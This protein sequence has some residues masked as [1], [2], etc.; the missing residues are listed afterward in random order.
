MDAWSELNEPAGASYC[1]P[2]ALIGSQPNSPT[3]RAA[4]SVSCLAARGRHFYNPIFGVPQR[5]SRSGALAHIHD[6][7]PLDKADR[8]LE[9]RKRRKV[10]SQDVVQLR[11]KQGPRVGVELTHDPL[12]IGSDIR[13]IE[14][15]DIAGYCSQ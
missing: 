6:V 13:I 5:A 2:N 12:E 11:N 7:G 10:L 15:R 3:D 9:Q 1:T 4:S 8:L 14:S